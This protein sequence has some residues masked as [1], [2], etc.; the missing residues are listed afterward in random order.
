MRA[1]AGTCLICHPMLVTHSRVTT[2]LPAAQIHVEGLKGTEYLD[3]LDSRK[4]KPEA[5][6]VL[7]FN[8]ELDRIYVGVPGTVQVITLNISIIS[9]KPHVP[10]E[11]QILLSITRRPLHCC[12]R[13]SPTKASHLCRLLTRRRSTPS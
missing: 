12:E 1:H 9:A 2:C 13:R 6:D 7:Q 4:R 8:S 3:N 5:D 11:K 10:K